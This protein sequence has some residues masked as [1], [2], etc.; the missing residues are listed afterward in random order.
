MRVTRIT[1]TDE[2]I[3]LEPQWNALAGDVPMHTWPWQGNWWLHYGPADT[4]RRGTAKL[5]VLCVQD[6]DDRMVGIAPWYIKP[7]RLHGRVVRFLAS[8]DVCSDY[9]SILCQPGCEETVAA[10]LA[11]WLLDDRLTVADWLDNRRADRWDMIELSGVDA[12]DRPIREL[13]DALA[14]Q[15]ALMHR[16]AGPSCWRLLLPTDWDQYVA[17]LSKSHR[18]QLRKLERAMFDAGRAVLHK[19]DDDVGLERAYQILVDLH[20]RR[21][22]TL[23]QAGAFDCPRFAA[24]HRDAM[25]GLLVAGQLRLAWLELDGAPIAVEYNLGRGPVLYSYQSGLDPAALEHQPG[26]LMTMSTVKRAISEGFA[27]YD[28]LRGDEPYKAHWGAAPRASVEIRVWP[29]KTVNRLRHGM[30]K[31][32]ESVMEWVRA[33]RRLTSSRS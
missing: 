13:A 5:F 30:W 18:K 29:A 23:G 11:D 7:S 28:F 9:Q 24:F 26:R 4:R 33:G 8:G 2:L 1:T 20:A 10:A 22:R 25:R 15:G 16:R 21:Q 12:E 32:G 6:A 3:A 19:V 27:A 31:A 17:S 14:A